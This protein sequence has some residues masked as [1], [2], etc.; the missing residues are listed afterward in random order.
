MPDV[1]SASITS[2]RQVHTK[3]GQAIELHTSTPLLGQESGALEAEEVASSLYD[4]GVVFQSQ[5]P[6][7]WALTC[8][9]TLVVAASRSRQYQ[10]AVG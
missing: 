6:R 4:G 8:Q 1:A 7:S 10:T 2:P 3:L 9:I 5:C